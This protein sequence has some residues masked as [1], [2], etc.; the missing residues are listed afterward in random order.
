MHSF[1][2]KNGLSLLIDS[3]TD[4]QQSQPDSELFQG[5][6]FTLLQ[7]PDSPTRSPDI[8]SPASPV[9]CSS[10]SSSSLS[11]VGHKSDRISKP[12]VRNSRGCR[13]RTSSLSESKVIDSPS[14]SSEENPVSRS[15]PSEQDIQ[16]RR[17]RFLF[18]MLGNST[19]R[20]YLSC[21]LCSS[22]IWGPNGK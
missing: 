1:R 10:T 13:S 8:L 21:R 11:K 4:Q 6:N 2:T 16:S 22:N 9:S 12:A 7:R 15:S 5:P 3:S 20:G 19:R 17:K 18:Q 14:V